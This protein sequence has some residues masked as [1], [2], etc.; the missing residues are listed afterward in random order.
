MES[1][2]SDKNI[3]LQNEENKDILNM[4]LDTMVLE[5]INLRKEVKKL[6]SFRKNVKIVLKS[7]GLYTNKDVINYIKNQDNQNNVN[8]TR[9][10][11]SYSVT[12]EPRESIKESIPLKNN[13]N[14]EKDENY[15]RLLNKN[16]K[17]EENIEKLNSEL[18][19]T[20]IN[21]KIQDALNKQK[22][23]YETKIEEM[24]KKLKNLNKNNPISPSVLNNVK[25]DTILKLPENLI[26]VVYNRNFYKDK[27]CYVFGL[28]Y[29]LN[30]CNII[31]EDYD[32]KKDK[33]ITCT[34]CF[35][36]YNFKEKYKSDD[37]HDALNVIIL[38]EHVIKNE[39]EIYNKIK[40]NNCNHI[41]NKEIE[42]CFKCK[43]LESCKPIVTKI[44]DNNT[45]I[46]TIKAF[47]FRNI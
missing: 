21:D 3:S 1:K 36:T 16:K 30:C 44:P 37:K 18:N 12:I 17:L 10:N 14:I 32:F 26:E 23:E 35:R 29:R 5:I 47:C 19:N 42:L 9:P 46:K 41:S 20:N 25:K 28:Q 45:G 33:N 11:P 27:Y 6:K 24:D 15:I 31:N 13:I 8:V 38:P 2:E 7:I 4:D 22:L 40:C 43:N 39:K 34:K